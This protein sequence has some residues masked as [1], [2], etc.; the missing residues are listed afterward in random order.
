MAFNIQDISPA[1]KAILEQQY[2]I[3]DHDQ[4]L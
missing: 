1:D 3:G 2:P 4:K